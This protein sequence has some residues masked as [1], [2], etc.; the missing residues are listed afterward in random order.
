[1][2]EEFSLIVF[3]KRFGNVIFYIIF[4]NA[5]RS[6]TSFD[7]C[8]GIRDFLLIVDLFFFLGS[9]SEIRCL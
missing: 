9:L 7:G 3:I 1:M 4:L 2:S 6:L 5:V 8:G